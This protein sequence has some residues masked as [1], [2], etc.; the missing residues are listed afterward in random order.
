MKATRIL[1]FIYLLTL[2]TL[3]TSRSVPN[4]N[5]SAISSYILPILDSP[6]KMVGY[7]ERDTLR[8]DPPWCRE[9]KTETIFPCVWWGELGQ[10]VLYQDAKSLNMA[11]DDPAPRPSAGSSLGAPRVFTLPVLALSLLRSV[12]EAF[13]AS[14]PLGKR[15]EYRVCDWLRQSQEFPCS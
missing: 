14:I 7:G 3:I 13:A 2:A 6:G 12:P 5:P 11:L 9:D 10:T 8:R 4:A 15:Q 1:N